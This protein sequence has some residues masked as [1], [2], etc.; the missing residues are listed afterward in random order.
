MWLEVRGLAHPRLPE[1]SFS[2]AEGESLALMGPSGAGKT[3]LLKIL[4]GLLPYR[5]EV[6]LGGRCVDALPP[7]RRRIGY[8]S[9]ELHLLP[10]LTV[11][12]NLQLAW[13]FG[14]RRWSDHGQIQAALELAQIA[15]RADRRPQQLSG[16]EKQ[17]AALA[18][19]LVASPQL[20]LL[21]EPFN[22]LDRALRNEV[23]RAFADLLQRQ[24]ITTLLV[25][26]DP[27]EARILTRRCLLLDQGQLME[28]KHVESVE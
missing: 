3:T 4:A 6:W 16:G 23:W 1:I 26:H 21:D 12:Q 9:Q 15:H 5:G 13:W 20:L 2:L 18:R 17:R 27:E 7:H 24:G 10:H 22:R 8:L 14:Q 25:T 11:R 19:A 28:V